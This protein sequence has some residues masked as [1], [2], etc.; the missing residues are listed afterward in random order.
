MLGRRS[1][2]MLRSRNCRNVRI[3]ATRVASWDVAAWRMW[4]QFRGLAAT[5]RDA[6]ISGIAILANLAVL[7]RGA[8]WLGVYQSFRCF[9]GR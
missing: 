3:A 1:D 4:R 9:S 6:R 5:L 7:A 8:L 2:A